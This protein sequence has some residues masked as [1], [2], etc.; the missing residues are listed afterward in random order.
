MFKHLIVSVYLLISIQLTLLLHSLL[1][2]SISLIRSKM[3]LVLSKDPIMPG[4][5]EEYD[6]DR[7]G[8]NYFFYCIDIKYNL[9]TGALINSLAQK[10]TVFTVFQPCK[11]VLHKSL[12]QP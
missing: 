10:F 3:S 2:K 7:S 1:V 4:M 5:E 6:P 11:T 8:L 12:S 9:W